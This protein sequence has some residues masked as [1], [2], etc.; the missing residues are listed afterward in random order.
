MR[1]ISGSARGR[2]LIA[3]V[4]DELRPTAD[5]VKEALFSILTS[6]L[7]N[8]SGMKVLD[9]FAGSGAIGIEA[10]SRGA[11]GAVFV[12]NRRGAT[13]LTRKNLEVTRFIDQGRIIN[14]DAA[15]AL[16]LLATEGESFDLVFLDPPY[17]QGLTMATLERLGSSTVI[18]DDTLVVAETAADEELSDSF[19]RLR[20]TDRRE[21]GDT[22][23][24]I[25]TTA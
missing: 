5:K 16:Q 23:L 13:Y 22:A 21:Y 17:R 3:P 19:G 18:N 15:A 9:L 1:V 2:R 7:G 4:G 14:R 12:D 6:R 24:F 11:A 20:V 25:L 10:L 8:L